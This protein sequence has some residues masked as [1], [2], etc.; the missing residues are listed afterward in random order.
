MD[1]YLNR[2]IRLIVGIDFGTSN[3]SI[4]VFREGQLRLFDLDH[5]N[6]NAKV[7]PSFTY[8][9]KEYDAFVGVQAIE[10]YLEQE[11]G[12]PAVWEKRKTG[13]VEITV[14]GGGQSPIIYT[15]DFHTEMD[16]AANGR[17]LQS[18]K[19]A[20]R[21]PKYEGTQVFNRFYRIEELIALLL[22]SLRQKCEQD[23][24]EPIKATVMGRPV[25]FSDNP[26]T[27]RR[28]QEK[29]LQAAQ[30]A[31]F[32]E[33][34]FELEP[35]GGAY[36]YHQQARSRENILV[37]DFG[38]GTL[39][40][41]IME[42]GGNR[43][44]VTIATQGVLLGGDDMNSILMQTLLKQFGEGSLT[45]D[46]YPFPS[47]IFRMLFSWQNMVELSRPEYSELFRE[48]LSGNDPD[49]IRRLETLVH[50][51]LGFKL[52][53][54][55][56]RVKITLSDT[57]YAQLQFIEEG[58]ALHEIITRGRF[59]KLIQE[60]LLNVEDALDELL[61]KSGLQPGQISAVLRTGGSSAIPA[62]IKLLGNRFG[63]D[64][65]KELN[66]FTTIVGGLAVKGHELSR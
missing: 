56:E 20:L 30:L 36:L 10:T 55:L 27:D 58:L 44:P 38:G 21:D 46:G 18:I 49:A 16:I 28:A 37:F 12:R 22:S 1:L 61:R 65:V 32:E 43:N 26:D 8:I 40:M 42:V 54:E 11:T 51:K 15:Q 23:L 66:L 53:R 34:H 31:G 25:K 17:L 60:D 64:R 57:Y 14:S 59:E 3:S 13:E 47:H 7:L 19:T 5:R 9:T 62:F 45:R 48:G 24:G 41:T 39:D 50:N 33:I 6:L 4:A 63:H 2:R 52:F 35:V 29:L